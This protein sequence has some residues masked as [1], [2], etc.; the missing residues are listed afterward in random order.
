[1]YKQTALC[2]SQ[3]LL[4]FLLKCKF[5]KNQSHF[6]QREILVQS[7]ELGGFHLLEVFL[8]V[9]LAHLLK[10][11]ICGVLLMFQVLT[12]LLFVTEVSVA[13]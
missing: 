8:P 1:M 10:G 5:Y 2:Q 3:L 4:F 9:C 12:N 11:Q 7:V 13:C 6:T